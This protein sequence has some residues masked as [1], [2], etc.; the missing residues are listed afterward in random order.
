MEF[1]DKLLSPI[2][3]A[4]GVDAA[5]DWFL[6][7]VLVPSTLLQTLTILAACLVARYGGRWFRDWLRRQANRPFFDRRVARVIVALAS[8]SMPAVWLVLTWM[9]GVVAS[10]AGW[11]HHL[12]TIAVS[13]LAVWVVVGA[14]SRLVLNPYW[15]RL[16]A[17]AAWVIAAL[18]I[19]ELLDPAIALLDSLAL[20]IGQFRISALSLVQAAIALSVLL[21]LAILATRLL[22]R[23]ISRAPDLTP[24]VQVLLVNLTKIALV[25]A[26]FLTALASVGID[27]TAFTVFGGALMVGLGFGLQKVAANL[28]S[29]ILLLLDKS[30]KPG[31]VIAIG[32][33]YGWIKSLGARYTSVVT[34]DNIEHIIP[35]EDFI[36]QRVENWS[37]SDTNLRLRIPFGISYQADPHQVIEIAKSAASEVDR[38]LEDPSPNCLVRGFG[39]SSVDME[40]RVWITDPQNGVANVTSAVLL[41]LWDEL[42]KMGVTIPYP[43]RDVHLTASEALPVQVVD[44]ET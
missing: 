1:V 31:D 38:I 43:Q 36:T 32:E 23:Q 8:I 35:N 4:L 33:T 22:E 21:W 14:A 37:Y 42:H 18:N 16:I 7:H 9:A 39:D 6:S 29:G 28:L 19:L 10:Q 34:R 11:P 26:A 2:H 17:S 13:L 40:L 5:R 27:L 30:I 12:L 25:A 20:S 41:A 24:S 15:A 44:P 3:P